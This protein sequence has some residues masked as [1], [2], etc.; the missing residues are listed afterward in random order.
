[1]TGTQASYLKTLSEP[2]HAPDPSGKQLTKAK[3][4]ELIDRL[5]EQ[6]QAG[7]DK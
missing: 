4:S 2:A 7:L 6:E 1:M 3:A 5:R